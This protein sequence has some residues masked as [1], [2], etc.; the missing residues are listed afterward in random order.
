[1]AVEQVALQIQVTTTL[2]MVV[3]ESLSLDMQC[4]QLQSQHHL[5]D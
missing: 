4:R 2:E 5:L 3:L 1:V